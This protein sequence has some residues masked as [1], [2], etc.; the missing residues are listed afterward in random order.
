MNTSSIAVCGA[1]IA[2]IASAYYLS[3]EYGYRNIVI[4]DRLAPMSYTTSKSGENFREYWPQRCM[5]EFIGHSI[6]L[7]QRLQSEHPGAFQMSYTGYDFVSHHTGSQIFPVDPELNSTIFN[8]LR[9]QDQIQSQKPYL[10]SSVKQVI[11]LNNGGAVD[12]YALGSLMFRLARE[13]GVRFIQAEITGIKHAA[14]GYQVELN[15]QDTLNSEKVII[16]AGPYSVELAQYL[17]I[18]LPVYSVAQRKV[19]MPDPLKIIPRDMPFTIYAD[20]QHLNWSDEELELISADEQFARLLDEYPAGLH[21]KPEGHNQIKLGWAF[22][23][24][25]QAPQWE[26]DIDPHFADIVLRGASRFI[27]GLVDYIDKIPAPVVQFSGY[28]TRTRDNLPVIGRLDD[29]LLIVSSLAGYGTMAGCA[30][31]QLCAGHLSRSS[32]PGYAKFFEPVRWQNPAL[33]Q[34]ITKIRDDGQL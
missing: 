14:G 11:H 20:R 21:I 13:N 24:Q 1:G 16:C 17:D 23:T 3:H 28:Y 12:V 2:G 25:A 8:V 27:P 33:M 4:I 19:V 30:A 26:I 32:L 6:E 5:N 7:M 29:N 22:N 10:D 18:A 9:D 15:H 34:E 31:G